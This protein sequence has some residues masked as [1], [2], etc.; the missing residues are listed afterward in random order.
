MSKPFD[1]TLAFTPVTARATPGES[2]ETGRK[3]PKLRPAWVKALRRLHPGPTS[4]RAG[5]LPSNVAE[6]ETIAT[7]ARQRYG[8]L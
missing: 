1:R 4:G 5:A 6:L 3:N 2:E 7:L 8:S